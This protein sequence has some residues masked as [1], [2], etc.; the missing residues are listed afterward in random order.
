MTQNISYLIT[1]VQYI[2]RKIRAKNGKFNWSSMCFCAVRGCIQKF[3]DWQP[4]VRTANGTA[5]CHYVQ[6]CRYSVSQPS[7]FCRHN[8]LCCFSTSNT[9]GKRIFRYDS[10]RKL[11]DTPTYITSFQSIEDSEAERGK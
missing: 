2:L 10:V 4:G 11:L 6:L 7:E 1:S 3:P 5:L 8:P 9:K